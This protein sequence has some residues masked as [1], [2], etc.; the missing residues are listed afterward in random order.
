[1]TETALILIDWQVGFED[2]TY[3]G[4]N[5]NNLD[6][7]SKALTLLETWRRFDWPIFHCIHHSQDPE[8]LLRIEKPSGDYI[9]GFKPL[10]NEAQ[11]VKNV[12][13]CFIGTDLET[14]LRALNIGDLVI[15]GLTT[16]HC[17]ST[18]TRM[19]GNLGFDVRLVGEACATFDRMGSDGTH[20]PAQSVHDISLANLH[21]EFCQVKRVQDILDPRQV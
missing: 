1:M 15:C 5:R 4:G 14:N 20:Y 6:A 12:N 13:S 2:H 17:V 16:N 9:K 11:I 18:T 19:A 21:G 10:A 3:W 7:E 8:S